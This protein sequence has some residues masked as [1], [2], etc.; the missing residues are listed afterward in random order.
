MS[1][2][3]TLPAAALAAAVLATSVAHAKKPRDDFL[4]PQPEGTYL[5][6]FGFFGPGVRGI[7]DNRIAIEPEMSE[8]QTQLIAD[9]NPG[10]SEGSLN[11]DVRFFLLSFGAGI[12]YRNDWHLLQFS[13]DASCDTIDPTTGKQLVCDHGETELNRRARWLKDN[14]YD[15]GV[16]RWPWYEG[17]FRFIVP[18][19]QLMGI[20]TTQFRYQAR[21]LS[22]RV[23]PATGYDL[24]NAF[25]WQQSTVFRDGFIVVNETYLLYR[26]RDLGFFGPAV[27]ILNVPRGANEA[28]EKR[29]WE[30]HYGIVAGAQVGPNNRDTVLLRVYTTLGQDNNVY[31]TQS[32]RAPIQLVLGYQ[33]NIPL[34]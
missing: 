4:N 22:S 16:K 10:Y 34:F 9:A 19:Y 3:T 31:G 8:I 2:R 11:V 5:R 33:A 32:F 15:W 18:M 20:S 7:L 29:E 17:R 12:G 26:N 21:G 25:D 27:R 28:V 1:R 24:Q 6:L 14:D 23:D 30:I 13:P